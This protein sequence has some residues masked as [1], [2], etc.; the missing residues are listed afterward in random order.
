MARLKYRAL[1]MALL[2]LALWTGGCTT[3]SSPVAPPTKAHVSADSN[4]TP[5]TATSAETGKTPTVA[6]QQTTKAKPGY[7]EDYPDVPKIEIMTEVDG[8]AIPRQAAKNESLQLV[9]KLQADVGNPLASKPTQ[10]VDGDT[11]TVRFP[12]EPK[13]LNAITEASAVKTYIL[14]YVQEGL[15]DQNPETFEYVPRLASKWVIEDSVK[16]SADY[17]GRERR[18]AF[19]GGSPQVSVEFDYTLP[20]PA[21]DAKGPPEP[22]VV[23]FATSD[24]DGK[25]IGGVWVGIYPVGKIEGAPTTGYHYWSDE[26]GKA[27]VSGMP[28]GKY[29]AKVGAEVYGKAARGTDGSLSVSPDTTENPLHETIKSS[30]EA[31][32]TLKPGEWSD[33]HE[34]TYYTYYLQDGAKWSDGTPFTAKDIEFAFALLNSP[35]VDGDHIRTYYSDLVECT[36][37][38][39][40]VVRMRYRQQYFKAFEFTF[41]ITLFTPPFHFFAKIF[42]DEGRELVLEHLTPEAEKETQKI[43]ARGQEFGKFFNNDSR[44]NRAPLGT[45]PYIVDKWID[46]DRVELKRN[47]NYWNNKTAGHLD[48]LVFKFIP[49]S[50]T[51]MAALKAGEIDFFYDMTPEQFFEDWPN[52]DAARRDQYVQASWY[53]P[54]FALFA[55]NQLAPQLKDRRVRIALT[56]LFDRQ[57]FVDTKLHG[58]AVVVSGSQYYFGPAYDRDVVPIGYDP[59]KASELLADAGWIDTDNDGILDRDGVKFKIVLRTAKGR[60]INT[61]RCLVLQKN[62]KQAGIDLQIEELEW[63]SFIDKV[64]AKECDVITLGWATTPEADPYQIFHGS[65]AGRHN[66]GSNVISF[67]NPQADSLIEQLRVTMDPE[68]RKRIHASF[69]RLLDSEQPYMFLWVPKEFGAYHKRFRGVK[70]YRLR[71]GFDLSEWYVP[72]DEQLH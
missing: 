68:K 22:P 53:Y 27:Q 4:E 25:A 49:D 3:S 51:A 11:V 2:T 30:N 18:I 16:L 35:H 45:G 72:K 38:S 14:Q 10:P 64:R 69:H 32:L 67:A 44:Y 71:P 7:W 61:Q 31:S 36:A 17:P 24:K 56:L 50:V 5:D 57:D 15:A 41:G 60:P 65:G 52:I 58:A 70:W 63:A 34:Q 6:D 13:V 9:G 42:K 55:W 12:S 21:T 29:T 23:I 47:P 48:R 33:L 28:T 59:E 54:N 40:K 46:K 66:R 43:S 19:E 1:W 62:L 37:L 8:I 20:A 39:P 26:H